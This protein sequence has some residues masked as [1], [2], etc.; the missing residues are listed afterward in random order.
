MHLAL[1]EEMKIA[2]EHFYNESKGCNW[3]EQWEKAF[4]KCFQKVD[5]EVG[6]VR[7]GNNEGTADATEPSLEAIASDAVGSTATVTVICSTHIIVANCGDSRAVL[8]RGKVS[9][10]LSIDHKVGHVFVVFAILPFHLMHF[11]LF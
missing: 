9:V 1:A 5:A 10:P 11:L 2:N 4:L 6:G 8:C 7:I 3:Q